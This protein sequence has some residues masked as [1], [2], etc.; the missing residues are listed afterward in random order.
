MKKST[1]NL[2]EDDQVYVDTSRPGNYWPTTV[3]DRK[4]VLLTVE[5]AGELET[6]Q[7]FSYW[8]V[9]FNDGGRAILPKY[10]AWETI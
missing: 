5:E 10:L 3:N 8:V 1:M 7:V 9:H 6:E 2:Q 4:G